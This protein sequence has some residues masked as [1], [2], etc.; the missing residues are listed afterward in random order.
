MQNR[1]ITFLKG[2]IFYLFH[3]CL[4]NFS[5]NILFYYTDFQFSFKKP[6]YA[7][8]RIFYI[9]RNFHTS[10]RYHNSNTMDYIN[11]KLKEKSNNLTY[12]KDFARNNRNLNWYKGEPSLQTLA[13]IGDMSNYDY[14]KRS[15]L[16]I[17]DFN[18]N[19]EILTEIFSKF[20]DF[21]SYSISFLSWNESDNKIISL[22]G[23]FLVNKT[24][25]CFDLLHEVY[26]SIDELSSRYNILIYEKITVKIRPINLL[27][28]DPVFKGGRIRNT[29]S[30]PT[31]IKLGINYKLLTSKY[32]PH[33]MDLKFYGYRVSKVENVLWFD[34]NNVYIKVVI[35]KINYN[36]KLEVYDKDLKLLANLEDIVHEDSFIREFK[37]ASDKDAIYVQYSNLN[38]INLERNI[39]VTFLDKIDTER[40]H[41]KNFL[42]FDIETYLD[43]DNNSVPYACGFFDGSETKS[44]YLDNKSGLNSEALLL[45]CINDM[46]S[47]YKGYHVYCH[48]FSKFDAIFL[49]SILHKYF[50]VSNIISK[51]INIISMQIQ[52]KLKRK[53]KFVDSFVLLPFSLANLGKDF[54]TSTTKGNFPYSFVNKD[55]LFYCGDMPDFAYY[56]DMSIEQYLHIKSNKRP[57]NMREETL[58][59]LSKDLICLHQVISKVSLIIYNKY[60]I[61]LFKHVTISGLALAIY[62]SNYLSSGFKLPNTRGRIEQCIRDA[63]YGGRTEVFI[64]IG[65]NLLSYDY[66]SLYPSAMLKPMPVGVPI[67][68]LC[69]DL[70]QIFGFV[71][72]TITTSGNNIPVLPC[73]VIRQGSSKL[74]FPNGRWT[75]WY[76]SE[77]LKLARDQ[78]YKI[79]VHESYM[80][81]KGYDYF[82]DYV[83]DMAFVKDN[84]RGAMREIHKLLLNTLYGRLGMNEYPDC[85]KIVSSEEALKIH[86]TNKVKD[87]FSVDKNKEYIRYNKKPDP[88]LCEQSGID[89]A[90]FN[91][92]DDNQSTL[93]TST[94]IAAAIASWSRIIMYKHIQEAFYTDT[95]SIFLSKE[96]KSNVGTEIGLF[97]QEYGLIT[98]AIFAGAKM[99]YLEKEDGTIISKSKGFKGLLSKN[100][101]IS[102]YNDEKV[103][104]MDERWK[105]SLELSTVK[106][107]NRAMKITSSY[108]KR[109]KLYSL[110]KWVTT[111]PLYVNEYFECVTT[112]LTILPRNR[113]IQV[114]KGSFR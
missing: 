87:N 102:L 99:Y 2:Y 75:G 79:E 96:L 3:L 95:D 84:S 91:I 55:N 51:D 46:L 42:T 64:P 23:H 44:Y 49:H 6:K 113:S 4:I 26:N 69:K 80:F 112:A 97:K 61:N 7:Y 70:N 31:D 66:N 81:D 56:K 77:E 38:L 27:V 63:Y 107:Y 104:V 34:Y 15:L 45:G 20:N 21:N 93:N 71:K 83:R 22:G 16:E 58:S 52:D 111:T 18:K 108:D 9:R 13:T 82:K 60:S 19:V 12:F 98:H 90:E 29:P 32:I 24:T 25:S 57:W 37:K 33:T 92:K 39:N 54:E 76:F 110:G 40:K 1:L 94:A 28:K 114:Y 100:D 68:S 50:K 35:I 36:H 62:R 5:F 53:L 59:Y 101:Y 47:K 11:K 14:S 17:A 48:N 43:K 30:L 65:Y 105:R 89:F 106:I 8:N 109:E 85:V 88:V 41:V 73:R 103:H 74:I 10:I 86:L 72:A 78:G 67:F